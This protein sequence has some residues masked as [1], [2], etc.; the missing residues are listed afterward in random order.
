MPNTITLDDFDNTTL[1][2]AEKALAHAQHAKE[3]CDGA[4]TA[5]KNATTCA[6]QPDTGEL[7]MARAWG[8]IAMMLAGVARGHQHMANR[9]AP[10]SAAAQQAAKHANLAEAHAHGVLAATGRD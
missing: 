6:S 8:D 7:E 2:R 5:S 10:R 1:D 3:A 4:D 9:F